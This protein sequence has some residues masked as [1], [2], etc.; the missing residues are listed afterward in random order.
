MKDDLPSYNHNC[1]NC[2]YKMFKYCLLK[3][4]FI[5]NAQ[6]INECEDFEPRKK[7]TKKRGVEI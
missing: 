2:Y 5:R 3:D 6:K 4:R 1:K 7:V